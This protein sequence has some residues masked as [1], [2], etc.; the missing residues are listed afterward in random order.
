MLRLTAQYANMSHAF[1]A[2]D[3]SSP[4]Q[5]PP[6]RQALDAACLKVGRDPASLPATAA[7]RVELD[8]PTPYTWDTPAAIRGS[9]DEIAATFWKFADEGISHLMLVM[10]PETPAAI[11]QIGRVIQL[12]DRGRSDG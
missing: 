6:F 2:F 4:D 7:V 3:G 12:M 8:G 9:L 5:V 1:L 10:S 11:E